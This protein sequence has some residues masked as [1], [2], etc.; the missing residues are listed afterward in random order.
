M[1]AHA[2]YFAIPAVSWSLLREM[3][4]SPAHFRWRQTHPLEDTAAMRF[5]RAVH[6]AVLEP[7]RFPL[8]WT[9]Y[10]G[11]RRGN[12]W[13]EFAAVNADKGIL[14]V[15]EYDR[16]LAIRDSVRRNRSAR[17]LLSRS[18]TEVTLK[19][20][21]PLTRMKC[22]ARLDVLGWGGVT[23]LKTTGR[24]L[25]ARTFGRYAVDAGYPEQ[26][27]FYRMG[28]AAL[29][30]GDVPAHI[31]AV[32]TTGP[33]DVAVFDIDEDTL[34]AAGDTVRGLL[35][36]VKDCRTRR[37]WPGRYESAVPLDTPPW[38]F[39]SKDDETLVLE[40]LKART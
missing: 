35:D 14:T 27:A 7:D 30:R 12:A 16:C 3:K 31:I 17:R 32:E 10:E 5:G 6:T 1:S 15:D 2:D 4:K 37:R 28:L 33:F 40:G 19:W 34:W 8:E 38:Y 26:L 9:L 39:D 11:A 21:D 20:V 13:T 23:D 25:D 36:Q 18:R 22:K 24:E 29:G